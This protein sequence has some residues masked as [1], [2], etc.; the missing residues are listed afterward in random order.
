ME[1]INKQSSL[2][3]KDFVMLLGISRD[4]SF[5]WMDTVGYRMDTVGYSDI[6]YISKVVYLFDRTS[7][8]CLRVIDWVFCF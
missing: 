7:S 5:V 6:N 4:L 2:L 8:P 1:K 3:L